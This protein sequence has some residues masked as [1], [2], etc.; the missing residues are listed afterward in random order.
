MKLYILVKDGG[1]GSYYPC[2]VLDVD[3]IVRLQELADTDV[4][5][6]E[7]GWGVDG[8]GFHYSTINIP[9]GTTAADLGVSVITME[10]VDLR[11]GQEEDE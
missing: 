5:D 7:N 9:D 2:Y 3:V 4:M 8:D 10:D 1:D 6:Y 11:F